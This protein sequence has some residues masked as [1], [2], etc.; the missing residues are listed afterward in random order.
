MVKLLVELKQ[1]SLLDLMTN[2]YVISGE[3]HVIKPSGLYESA[4]AKG[5]MKL[6]A[7]L[8]DEASEELL[9]KAKSVKEFIAK[10]D[11]NKAEPEKKEGANNGNPS[12]GKNK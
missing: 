8:K 1:G 10:Y 9:Q 11:A 2:Q 6:L 5:D 4:I 7:T 12:G 3:P